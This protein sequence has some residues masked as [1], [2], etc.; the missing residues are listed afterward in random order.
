[1]ANRQNQKAGPNSQ[2]LQANSI[3]VNNGIDEK[4][5]REICKEMNS[6]LRRE[7]SE[8]ALLIANSRVAQFEERLIPKMESVDGAL[9]AFG[10]PSFQL[11]LAEAQKTAAASERPTDYDLLSE[12]L[13]HRFQKG[14]DRIVRAGINRAV[15]IVDE[16]SDEALL[17]LTTIYCLTQFYPT[18]GSIYE[19]LNV[20]DSLFEKILYDKLPLGI[21]WLDHLDIL[22]AVRINSMGS[23]KKLDEFYRD[24]LSGYTDVGINQESDNYIKAIKL[25]EDCKLPQNLLVPHVFNE[26]YYR[27]DIHQIREIDSIKLEF[28]ISGN[29]NIVKIPYQTSAEQKENLNLIY[30]L[31]EQNAELKSEIVRSFMNELDKLEHLKILRI[32]WDELSSE[33]QITSVGK[34]LAHSNAERC[35]K[36]LPTLR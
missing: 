21:D 4:R 17:G 23:L 14:D 20:L 7:Y 9:E 15:N 8:E 35:Y 31:Y 22:D 29:G 11:L 1:M 5:A 27:L 2:Q 19:G 10:D 3:I 24:R 12:L 13:V 6:Q 34:V 18:V 32:W 36:N 26:N 25:L 30:E 28:K 33:I 16:I